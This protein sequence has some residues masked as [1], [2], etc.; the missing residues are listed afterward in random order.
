[1][2]S[3]MH[4]ALAWFGFIFLMMLFKV[5]FFLAGGK[6]PPGRVVHSLHPFPGERLPRRLWR[7]DTTRKA[8]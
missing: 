6:S 5:P 7:A 3:D 4:L 1:M 8:G 2:F